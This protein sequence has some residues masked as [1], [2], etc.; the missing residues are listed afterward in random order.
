[1]PE[2]DSEQLD[3]FADGQQTTPPGETSIMG[4]KKR[5]V[6]A[7][8]LR[9]GTAQ[10]RGGGAPPPSGGGGGSLWDGDELD[11]S[12]Q[13][14]T[15]RRYLNYALSVITSR[16]L[17]DVRDGL[18]PVQRRI[19]YAMAHDE[20]L[21]PDAKH[22]KSAKVVGSVIGRYHPH[23]DTAVYDAMVRMA[24]D[25]SLR[26]PLVDGSGNFGSLDGDGAA[27]YRYTEAR[28][29]PPAM[30]LLRELKQETVPTRQNY[31]ATT[32]EP[33]VLPARFP[34]LLANG[35]TG[36]AV[37]MATNIPPHNLRELT[38]ALVALADNRNLSTTGILKHIHGPDFP[39]GGQMLNNKVELRQIYDSGQGAIRIRAEYK[40][41]PRKH[42]GVNVIIHSI[43]Y[44]INKGTLV[45]RV[46]EVIV[47]RKLP[48]LL[49]VRDE[50]TTDV[51]IVLE[52]KR[53]AD[54]GMVMAYLYKQTPLQMNFNANF[55]CLVPTENPEI[56]Q[57]QRLGIKDLLTHFLDFRFEV[58]K[59]R[60]EYELA[61]LEKRL[62]I[63]AGFVKI[64]DALDEAIRIIRRSDGRA[65]A[66]Q[67][68]MKRFRL[69]QLQVDAI[70][71]LRLYKLAK[72]E[73]QAIREE[74]TDKR[75]QAREIQAILKSKSRLWGVVK[76]ELREVSDLYG[77]PRR[78]KYGGVGEEPEFDADAYIVDEDAHVV[79]TTDGW[80]KRIRE[81]K[82]PDKL[83]VREG[84]S[85]MAVLP[86]STRENVAFFTNHGV[87]YVIKIN[88][89]PATTGYGDPAQKLFKFSDGERIVS[90]MTLDPRAVLPDTLL[91]VSGRGFGQR[92]ALEPYQEVTTR[93]GRK[94][95]RPPKGDEI[96]GVVG[97]AEDDVVISATRN[98]HVLLCLAYEINQLENPGKGVIVIKTKGD[99]RVI[100]FTATSQRRDRITLKN[101][102]TG[103][104]YDVLADPTKVKARG[105][106]GHQIVKRDTLELVPP[107]VTIVPLATANGG[108]EVH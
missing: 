7:K 37:G 41:E 6:A 30:E 105:G 55:T 29:A 51:R 57:P 19:L 18:K 66:A 72:L 81:V 42:G 93:A 61:V 8:E 86:G 56:G 92:F 79:V 108:E 69:D 82:D 13:A 103:A 73:I 59:R 77:T 90:A 16:A 91:A 50:S 39:T 15:R 89:V 98:G 23:G 22:R 45:E 43:P 100:G 46:A 60:F 63:L 40:T 9:A 31:D 104:Q 64:F 94:F 49:D 99:D 74:L 25:F 68:L 5:P 33:V 35:S 28:L 24:Q 88:D 76:T 1:V 80:L 62:H 47:A 106:K 11:A 97:A 2:R 101:T 95:A 54:P 102:K 52:V 27:A 3:L 4:S 21:Y 71:D 38:D 20:R 53:G 84:D 17:P 58:T 26:V 83:R 14:E 12:L 96:V 36:I 67:Q 70:L 65:D 48:Q 10:K 32:T 44:G 75:A 78:T 85:V 87:A 34:N 107:P